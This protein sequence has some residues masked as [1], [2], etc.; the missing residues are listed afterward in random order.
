MASK[1]KTEVNFHVCV[2][3]DEDWIA[4]IEKE[5]SSYVVFINLELDNSMI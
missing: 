1:K 4:A 5:V 2:D 3:S